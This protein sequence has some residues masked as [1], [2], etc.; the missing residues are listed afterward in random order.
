MNPKHITIIGG[1]ISGLS[2]AYFLLKLD[3]TLRVTILEADSRWGGKIRT[4]RVDGFVIEGGPDCFLASKPQATALCRELG[5]GDQLQGTNQKQRST[6]ILHKNRL[7]PIPAGLVSMVPTD[8]KAM[9][10][11]P[12][13]TWPQKARMAL[14]FVLPPRRVDHP[15]ESVGAFVSRRLGRGA[16]SHLI[17]PLIAG[18]YTGDGDQL[19]IAAT[20]PALREMEQQ[21]GGL[22]RGAL[23]RRKQS[24]ASGESSAHSRA[25]FLTPVHG[26]AALP[27]AIAAS[28]QK[29]GVEMRL[30]TAV[31]RITPFGSGFLVEIENCAPLEVDAVIL[32]TPAHAS[33]ALLAA[34]DPLLASHLKE[35]PLAST[36]TVSLAYPLAD[37]PR[38]LNGYGYVIPR[39]EQRTAL[40]CTWTSSKFDHRAPDGYALLRIFIGRAGEQLPDNDDEILALAC[41][42][43]AETMGIQSTPT[44]TR[45]FRWENAMPQYNLGHLERMKKIEAAGKKHKHLALA[46]N[47]YKGVGIPDCIHSGMLAAEKVL[48]GLATP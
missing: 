48:S 5:L 34:I 45:I 8:F 35:I 14:D 37:L 36:A 46:G 44:L 16:Y 40:A 19:S 13:L 30:N 21:H 25:T 4:E 28:L 2:A 39:C 24:L 15:E 43:L 27:E 23:A 9:V 31:S 26:L 38:A 6:F 1:G 17:Q 29:S 7:Q 20:F 42:E 22:I 12:L 3:P 41:T 33:A 10:A 11:T 32:A 47:I 18:I